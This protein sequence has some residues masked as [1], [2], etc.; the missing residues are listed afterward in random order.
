MKI[1]LRL[2]FLISFISENLMFIQC[3]C[4][5]VVYDGGKRTQ[6]L[7]HIYES[8]WSVRKVVGRLFQGFMNHKR[9]WKTRKLFVSFN[10]LH[11]CFWVT[12]EKGHKTV[13]LLVC[14]PVCRP[15]FVSKA[16]HLLRKRSLKFIA[17]KRT[18][19]KDFRRF[20]KLTSFMNKNLL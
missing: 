9:I 2:P 8:Y 11:F 17:V 19:K 14:C 4:I 16:K 12:Q 18:F 15:F 10:K 1:H 6:F 7:R 13:F 5:Y 3:L 20:N